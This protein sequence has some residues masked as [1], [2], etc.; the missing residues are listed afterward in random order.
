MPWWMALEELRGHLI[1]LLFLLCKEEHWGQARFIWYVWGQKHFKFQIIF[2]FWDTGIYNEPSWYET[3]VYLCTYTSSTHPEAIL[4][5]VFKVPTFILQSVTEVQVWNVPPGVSY[6]HWKSLWFVTSW[7]G[8]SISG[9]LNLKNGGQIW[10]LNR[11][12]QASGQPESWVRGATTFILNI[13]T[14]REYFIFKPDKFGQL[15]RK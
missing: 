10:E 9:T 4:G 6:Q 15:Y 7:M 11:R 12:K 1:V 5:N 13:K 14:E 3:Q 8:I 2:R